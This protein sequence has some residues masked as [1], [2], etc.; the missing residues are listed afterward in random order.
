MIQEHLKLFEQYLKYEKRMSAH[1]ILAY[2]H[3]LNQFTAYLSGTY[4]L[5][6]TGRIEALHVRSFLVHLNEFKH[7]E[8][9]V[10]RKIS[11]IKSF[12][13]FLLKRGLIMSNPVAQIKVPKAPA[14]LP[15][16]L[17]QHQSEQLFS[18]IVY[19]AGLEG[20]TQQLVM[21]LLYQTGIRRAELI[22]LKEA[23][24]DVYRNE[25]VVLGKRN[26]ERAIPVGPQLVRLISEYLKE[27]KRIIV[28]EHNNLLTLESGKPLY[29]NYV[30]RV[31]KRYLG[32]GITTISKKS[33]HVMRHTFATHLTHNGAGISAIKE[34]LGHSSLAA[35]Q[36]YTHSNIEYLKKIYQ[37]AHP[38]A[39]NES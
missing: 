17:E 19:P 30:Y 25:I 26:K 14:R 29:D 13:K 31:V 28:S 20:L 8:R 21:E 9:S 5:E 27:K 34:L 16:F 7:K 4:E 3:D 22:H 33:P 36:I 37:Q 10:Q 1:T 38:K 11:S 12:F 15:V 39:T 6:D 24:V 35:T 2:A 23:D 32:E 18:D